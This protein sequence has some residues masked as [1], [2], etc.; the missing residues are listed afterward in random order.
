MKVLVK[1]SEIS[2]I[3]HESPNPVDEKSG[4]DHGHSVRGNLGSA[5]GSWRSQI[6]SDNSPW[7]SFETYTSVSRDR[8]LEHGKKLQKYLETSFHISSSI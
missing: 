4:G 2:K 8:Y 7:L 6:S 1:F 5:S 3:Y